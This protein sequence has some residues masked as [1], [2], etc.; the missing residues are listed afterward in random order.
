MTTNGQHL[1]NVGNKPCRTSAG[2]TRNRKTRFISA[3]IHY[4]LTKGGCK[5]ILLA[6]QNNEALNNAAEEIIYNFR[7]RKEQLT[8]VRVGEEGKLTE[9]LK[10]FHTMAVEEF[11]KTTLETG[12]EKTIFWRQKI[13]VYQEL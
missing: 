4:A 6:S 7:Q 5:N 9:F 12:L 8:I 13:W 3:F 2:A 11:T 10:L 1:R